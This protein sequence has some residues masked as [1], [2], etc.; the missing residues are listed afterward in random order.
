MTTPH[1]VPAFKFIDRLAKYLKENVDEVQPLSWTDVAKTGI[2]VEKQPQ[3]PD[4]WYVRSASVLRKVY[5]HGPIG[6]EDLRADY[7]GRKNRGSKPDG[8]KKAG[9][10]NIRKILQQLEAAG[11]VVTS[12]PE[13]R[14]MSPK[15]RKLLQDIAGDLAKELIKTIP[16][17]KKYQGE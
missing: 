10:S 17:L 11:L 4:W 14:K 2:H 13:G 12:R 3:N 8:V 7:G 9:G 15:G 1:D 6:L 5:L 16:E